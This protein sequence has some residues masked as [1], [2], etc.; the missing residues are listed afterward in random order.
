[1]I[2][3]ANILAKGN[4]VA[5]SPPVMRLFISCLLLLLFALLPVLSLAQENKE[6]VIYFKNGSIL[7]GEIIEQNGNQ[8]LK[9]KT[10]GRNVLVV[11]LEEVKEIRREEIPGRQYF[12]EK[13]YVNLTGMNI[14]PGGSTSTVSFQMVNGYQFNSRLSAGI[15]IGFVLYNDPLNLMPLFF[16]VKYK[17]LEANTTPFV[18]FK[19]GYSFSILSDESM[20][21]ESHRGGFMMNPGVG[22]Q[23]DTGGGFGIY[24]SAGYNLDNSSFEQEGFNERTIVTDISYRR[25]LLGFGLTF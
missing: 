9:I 1:M 22:L 17:F 3:H 7:R 8:S 2:V 25:L 23:F 10:V 4:S 24:F 14:L 6:D 19:S 12:K 11:R 5:F 15:G 18:F 16:D 20:E 21:V 13:G